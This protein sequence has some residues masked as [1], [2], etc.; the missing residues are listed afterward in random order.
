VNPAGGAPEPIT[1][2]PSKSRKPFAQSARGKVSATPVPPGR[3]RFQAHEAAE[4]SQ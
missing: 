3:G 2:D 4:L 1:V